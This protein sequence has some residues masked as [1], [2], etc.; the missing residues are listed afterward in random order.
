MSSA[1]TTIPTVE[2]KVI[3]KID[4]NYFYKRFDERDSKIKM[5]VVNISINYRF[6][7]STTSESIF[8]QLTIKVKFEPTHCIILVINKK[9][10]TT[11]N[12]SRLFYII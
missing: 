3:G 6:T 1:K 10:R 7:D 2:C 9:Y 12:G 11:Q 8:S 4:W 5:G